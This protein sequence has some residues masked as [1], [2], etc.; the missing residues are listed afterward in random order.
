M[1]DKWVVTYCVKSFPIKDNK[2]MSTNQVQRC[3]L[4]YLSQRLPYI[5]NKMIHKQQYMISSFLGHVCAMYW[6]LI[7]GTNPMVGNK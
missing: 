5:S 2:G 7:T 6:P 3:H 1:A 4:Q